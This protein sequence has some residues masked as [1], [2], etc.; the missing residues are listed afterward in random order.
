MKPSLPR[1][2]AMSILALTLV[3]FSTAA[4]LAQEG[5]LRG[6]VKDAATGEALIGANVLVV[7]TNR[8]GGVQYGR[9]VPDHRPHTRS[10]YRRCSLHRLQEFTTICN[11]HCKSNYRG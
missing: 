3:L 9:G 1:I 5:V 8:G 11:R 4:V 10:L 2:L 6:T 7:G